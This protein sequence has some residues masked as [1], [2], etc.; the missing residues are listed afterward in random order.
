[1]SDEERRK[2]EAFLVSRIEELQ[3]QYQRATE[4]Y[5][6]ELARLRALQPS[7]VFILEAR[8]PGRQRI[9]LEELGQMVNR[10]DI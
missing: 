4:P 5:V 8:G 9:T 6:Q 2:F 10:E 7:P 3:R 1:M